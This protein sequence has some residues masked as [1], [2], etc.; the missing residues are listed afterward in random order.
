[1][2]THR[3]TARW[4]REPTAK[5]PV[6]HHWVR[7][8]TAPPPPTTA[9]PDRVPVPEYDT[10]TYEAHLTQSGWT[11]EETDY[12]VQVYGDCHGKWT[13]IV[14]HY[15]FEGDNPRTMEELKARFYSLSATLL[16]LATP[17]TSMTTTDYSLYEMLSNFNA[18]QETSRK[19]LAEG[20]LY[21][22]ANEVDEETVLLGELQ[23][24]M[25]NQASL[26]SQREE[27]RQRLD[28]P[29]GNSTGYS[30]TTSQALTT[31]WQQL[32][33]Q[34]R[35]K[36]HSKLRPTGHPAYDGLPSITNNSNNH[37]N[38]NTNSTS[39][40]RPAQT[41]TQPTLPDALSKADQLRF[42]VTTNTEKTGSSVSFLG[43]RFTKPRTAKS[44]LQTEK[45]GAILD[46]IGVPVV[47]PMA[48]PPV[49]AAFEQIM[50]KVHVLMDQ[51]KIAEK[52]TQEVR[53]RQ[54]ELSS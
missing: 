11:K 29:R 21:R 8:G 2:A 41:P 22:R 40:S 37:N 46:T 9:I 48:T 47:I 34:D 54:S 30:Y 33:T 39:T 35:A 27:L 19:K 49:V 7:N 6:L 24:I 52:D 42:G 23:R 4:T 15:D 3:R 17:I 50:E 20:H 53:V 16:Q 44:Q 51:R 36:K 18:E 43:D 28:H 26:D 45:L 38:T 31:L 13:V 14:D 5:T 12:L 10:E 25:L 1:M 32:L